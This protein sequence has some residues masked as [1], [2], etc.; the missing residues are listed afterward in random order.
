MDARSRA[1]IADIRSPA[2][3]KLH[4]V[5]KITR[6]Q[7]PRYSIQKVR[8]SSARR[9][10]G[11]STGASSAR[12]GTTV[13]TGTSAEHRLRLHRQQTF[14]LQLLAGQL[15]RATHGFGLL[16]SLLLRRLL[17]MTAELHLAENTLTLHLLLERLESLIDIII[18]NENLHAASSSINRIGIR[19]KRG[20]DEGHVLN[21]KA[22]DVPDGI[23]NVHLARG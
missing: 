4:P 14:A 13:A 16:A 5:K 6:V 17:V 22:P 2:R 8:D 10:R 1:T 3:E 9:A 15:A 12:T 7:D 20:T 11:T 21:F 18:A 23:R 19:V